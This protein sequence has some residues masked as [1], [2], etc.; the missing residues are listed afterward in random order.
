M[1][2]VVVPVVIAVVFVGPIPFMDVPSVRVM[3][4]VRMGPVG[5]GIRGTLP[6]AGMPDPAVAFDDPIAIYPDITRP[7]DRRG[8]VIAER[9][10]GR[11]DIDVKGHLSE[12]G[13]GK[14]RS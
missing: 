1:M 5:S 6:C 13:E 14:S 4:I 12:S 11:T 2:S 8:H 7:G 10:R 9:G 3:I